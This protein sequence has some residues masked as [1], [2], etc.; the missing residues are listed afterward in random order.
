MVSA[1]LADINN[2]LPADTQGPFSSSGLYYQYEWVVS[3][4]KRS[5]QKQQKYLH[6]TNGEASVNNPY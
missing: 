5:L 3:G 6:V 1:S 2:G 4:R